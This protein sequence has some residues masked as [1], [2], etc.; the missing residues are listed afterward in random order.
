[1]KSSP[2]V[3]KQFEVMQADDV[4]KITTDSILLGAWVAETQARI[5]LDIGTGC[6][7]LALMLAQKN[8]SAT[9]TAID[10]NSSALALA[11]ANFARSPYADRLQVFCSSVQSFTPNNQFDLIVS[12]PPYFIADLKAEIEYKLLAKH[13]VQLSYEDLIKHIAR[14]LTNNGKAYLVI[15][16]FNLDILEKT[17]QKEM[18]HTTRRMYILAVEDKS[19]H[20][21]MVQLEKKQQPPDEEVITIKDISGNYTQQFMDLTKAFYLKF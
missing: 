18:L 3:F 16:F 2:F 8:T 6:G 21:V 5:V 12:N 9:V 11:S 14:L 4:M 17:A 20:L 15:P 10:I 13:T 7:L 1:M 19:P